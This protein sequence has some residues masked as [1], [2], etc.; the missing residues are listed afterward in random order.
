MPERC[1]WAQNHPLLQSYHDEEW[2]V[3]TRDRGRLYEFL[4]LEGAQ[5]GL[6]WLTVLKRRDAYRDALAGF[7][8]DIVSRWDEGEVERLLGFPGLIHNRAKIASHLRNARHFLAVEDEFGGFDQYLYQWTEQQVI[9]HRYESER[10]V[11]ATDALAQAMSRDLV[12]RGFGFVGPTI[13][14]SYLQAIGLIMDHVTGCFRFHEL[15]SPI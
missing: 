5:A 9:V 7:D 10:Q 6:S 8:P 15:T 14:Y 3:V 1:A 2:G 12:K 11:P 13:C 4:V